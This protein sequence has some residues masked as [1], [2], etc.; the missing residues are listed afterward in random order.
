MVDR[1]TGD[2]YHRS[3]FDRCP[4][5]GPKIAPVNIGQA[6]IGRH[7]SPSSCDRHDNIRN[8]KRKPRAKKKC[9]NKDF[10]RVPPIR[11]CW[12]CLFAITAIAVLMLLLMQRDGGHWPDGCA[13]L[14]RWRSPNKVGKEESTTSTSG[15]NTSSIFYFVMDGEKTQMAIP[16]W[17]VQSTDRWTRI[18]SSVE[19]NTSY[20]LLVSWPLDLTFLIIF[21]LISCCFLD[22][23]LACYANSVTIRI[24][25]ESTSAY[26]TWTY[27]VPREVHR[28][29]HFSIRFRNQRIL[30]S[31]LPYRK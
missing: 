3:G 1:Q 29:T 22:N 16:F 27:L 15:M 6:V 8:K 2:K 9:K 26:K 5:L 23:V 25:D 4:R 7:E 14:A 30:L 28:S 12:I 19:Y 17:A 18:A 21:L 24:I 13:I 20:A 31:N 10:S 11:H